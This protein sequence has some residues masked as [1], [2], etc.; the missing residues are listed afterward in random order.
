MKLG[1]MANI[2]QNVDEDTVLVLADE[3]GIRR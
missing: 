1:I 2:N 3:L